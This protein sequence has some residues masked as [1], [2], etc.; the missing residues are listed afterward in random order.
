STAMATHNSGGIVIVQVERIANRGSLRPKD[1][2]IPSI[3]VDYV[4]VAEPANHMQTFATQYSPSFAGEVRVPMKSGQKLAL[5]ERKIIARRA[6]LELRP[7]DI[8]NLG[9]GVPE[10]V[11]VVANEEK[12]L[13]YL[14]MTVEP[15]I[16]GGMPTGGLDFGAAVNPEAI[17]DMPDQFDFYDGGGLDL[18][19]L[20]MAQCDEQGN[21][22]SSKFGLRLAG[23][24]GFIDISQNAKKTLFVGTFTAGGLELA[25][26]H[27]NLRIVHEG[28]TKKFV[29]Q[30]DQITFSGRIG[31]T[32]GQEIFFMTERCI[33]KLQNRQ[34]ALI[35][36]APGIDIEKDI[37]AHMDFRPVMQDVKIMDPRIFRPS[38]MGIR[39]EFLKYDIRKRSGFLADQKTLFLNLKG[40]EAENTQDIEVIKE[41]IE[42]MCAE[43]GRK[44]KA[45]ATYAFD[46]DE[47]LL[48]AYTAMGADIAREHHAV[49]S[50]FNNREELR[51]KLGDAF[52]KRALESKEYKPGTS[53]S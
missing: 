38:A 14:T 31:A 16:I 47:E 37:L 25:I 33:F 52:V 27:G 44:I 49:V 11:S 21:V 43:A 45:V 9:I 7:Y 5:D 19:C 28:K 10:G 13:D 32:S 12:I 30:V 39:K 6:T 41:V 36:V 50:H 48:E 17:I 2:K 8:I 23:C 35:E 15:G 26:D 22:N 53:K 46:I 20:G 34:V 3:L 1:V 18:A 4:V 29:R 42:Q 51:E 40:L 24:G